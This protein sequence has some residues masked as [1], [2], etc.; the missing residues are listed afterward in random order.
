MN[1]FIVPHSGTEWFTWQY[2][3]SRCVFVGLITQWI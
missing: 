2:S 1:E 3:G